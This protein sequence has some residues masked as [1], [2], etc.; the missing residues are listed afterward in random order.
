MRAPKKNSSIRRKKKFLKWILSD[1]IRVKRVVHGLY[2]Q[3]K[4]KDVV[5]FH[6]ASKLSI[7]RRGNTVG[8]K[9]N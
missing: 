8:I 2:V 9:L 3:G 6:N 1:E 4:I 5:A 7:V